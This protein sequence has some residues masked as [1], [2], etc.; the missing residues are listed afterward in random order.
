M[1][2]FLIGGLSHLTSLSVQVNRSLRDAGFLAG[3]F[4]PFLL[5]FFA[6]FFAAILLPPDR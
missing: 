5:N 1:S 4:A 6:V 2:Y 3:F